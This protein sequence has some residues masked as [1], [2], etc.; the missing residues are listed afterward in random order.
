MSVSYTHLGHK[1]ATQA[2][3][4]LGADG[5]V[6]Q[7]RFGGGDAPGAGLGLDKGGVQ[8]VY[9]RQERAPMQIWA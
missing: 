7:V 4:Q 3:A 5:D 8:D 2:A 9:K 6:L 1:V